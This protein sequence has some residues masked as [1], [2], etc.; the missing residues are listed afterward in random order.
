[1][2][3]QNRNAEKKPLMYIVQADYSDTQSS[4]QDILIK[5]RKAPQPPEEEPM[6]GKREEEC[7]TQPEGAVAVEPEKQVPEQHSRAEEA[8]QEVPAQAEQDTAKPDAAKKEPDAAEKEP[9]A[10]HNAAPEEK[11]PPKRVKKPMSRMSILEKIDFLTK[12]PHNMPRTLCLIEAN[13][14]TYRGVIVG[15][16]N[17][18]IF[19]RTTSNGA[20]AELAIDDITSLHPLG[21]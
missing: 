20:P 1:M 11:V 10:V 18:A 3:K 7:Q 8:V 14:K 21:F 12:L 16:K 15:R 13:G 9:E 5:K 4:M 19:L 2:S 17:N 6:H